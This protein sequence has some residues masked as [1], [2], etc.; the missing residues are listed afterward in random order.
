MPKGKVNHGNAEQLS[1]QAKFRTNNSQFRQSYFK[2][3]FSLLEKKQRYYSLFVLFIFLVQMFLELFSVT[4][5][6]PL[7]SFLTETDLNKNTFS[8]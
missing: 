7:I 5:F 3:T 1:I 2:K 8:F 6:I 4:L